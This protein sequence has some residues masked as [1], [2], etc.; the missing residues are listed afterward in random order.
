MRYLA[1]KDD[2]EIELYVGDRQ[3]FYGK[4][5]GRNVGLWKFLQD[6]W[7]FMNEA[8][9]EISKEQAEV[10][11]QKIRKHRNDEF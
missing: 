2:K 5:N 8:G 11:S 10:I 3:P 4:M 9:I 6:D 1:V 7:T